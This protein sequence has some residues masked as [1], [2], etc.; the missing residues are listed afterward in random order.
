MEKIVKVSR[1]SPGMEHAVLTG[2]VDVI[3]ANRDRHRGDFILTAPTLDESEAI[4]FKDKPDKIILEGFAHEITRRYHFADIRQVINRIVLR[5][6]HENYCSN[7]CHDDISYH[8]MESDNVNID[9]AIADALLGI[10]TPGF[11]MMRNHMSRQQEQMVLEIAAEHRAGLAKY[12]SI[13]APE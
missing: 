2:W 4:L 13:T 12:G 1:I 9:I 6:N 10:E 5:K 3:F 11:K 8:A 7:C